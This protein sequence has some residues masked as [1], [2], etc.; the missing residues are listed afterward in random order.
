MESTSCLIVTDQDQLGRTGA[1]FMLRNCR[2]CA[3][4]GK[5]CS[6]EGVWRIDLTVPTTK[7]SWVNAKRRSFTTRKPQPR[8]WSRGTAGKPLING[9]TNALVSRDE[10]EGSADDG[11]NFI[12][13]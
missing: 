9:E 6:L 12:I 10:G 5:L 8:H 2:S 4:G 11:F 1:D 13:G 3:K 7:W